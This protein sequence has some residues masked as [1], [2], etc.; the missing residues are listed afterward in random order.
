M[1]PTLMLDDDSIMTHKHAFQ[2]DDTGEFIFT[3]YFD[4]WSESD[5]CVIENSIMVNGELFG[6]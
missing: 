3:W 6:D 2:T 1:S 5:S 4:Q